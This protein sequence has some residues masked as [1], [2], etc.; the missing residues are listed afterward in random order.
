MRHISVLAALFIF[1]AGS[2][3]F[4]DVPKILTLSEIQAGTKAVGFTVFSGVEPQRFDVVLGEP[5]DAGGFYYVLIKVSGGPMETPLEKIGAMSGMSGSPIFVDCQE[6]KE[7][8]K[9]GTLAGALSASP[10]LFIEGGMNTLMTPIEYMLGGRLGGY[11]AMGEFLRRG[12]VFK[13]IDNLNIKS[14]VLFSGMNGQPAGRQLPRCSEFANS[15]IKPGSMISVFL[16]RGTMNVGFSGTVTW[17]DGEKIYALGHPAFGTGLVEY[18]FWQISVAD[19]IQSPVS[20]T[21]IPGCELD[22]HGAILVDGAFEIA[23][24]VGQEVKLTPLDV[25]MFVGNQQVSLK[26]G[27]VYNSPMTT[28]ILRMLP[29]AWAG[30]VVGDLGGLSV[31][32]QARITI[33]NQPELFWQNVL[34]AEVFSVPFAE[35]FNRVD[36]AL[37]T[38]RK[39]GF[40]HQVESMHIDLGFSND[41]RVW[42]KKSAFISKAKALP[43]ET[44]HVQIVLEDLVRGELKHISIPIQIPNDFAD[45]VDLDDSAGLPQISVLVQGGAHFVDPNDKAQKSLLTLDVLIER[46]NKSTSPPANVLYVQQTLPKL[47]DKKEQDRLATQSAG[48]SAGKWQSMEA[49]ELSNLPSGSQFEILVEK[50]PALEHYIEFEE[51]FVIKV[52]IVE[53]PGPVQPEKKSRRKWFWIF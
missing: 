46:I 37:Q 24:I 42:K 14:L 30:Q 53:E 15:D 48:V 31:R 25:H 45:R 44:V 1:F 32:Y 52:E 3:V 41:I 49:G 5:I 13:K 10:G 33:E 19:T 39:S 22:A 17:R 7:C 43:G 11:S 6:Y 51:S 8:V 40:S 20:G 28:A 27:L 38:I 26:E 16:A 18:P 47:K 36:N 50:A 23:G 2:P 35:L 21:K 4:A 12:G 9:S 29:A 34:P